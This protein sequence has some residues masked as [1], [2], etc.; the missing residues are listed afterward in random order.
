MVSTR[1]CESLSMGSTPIHRPKLEIVY[2]AQGL[3]DVGKI[4]QLSF[5]CEHIIHD[6]AAN[7]SIT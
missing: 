7:A 5:G 1:D 3:S 4:T 6:D 2:K